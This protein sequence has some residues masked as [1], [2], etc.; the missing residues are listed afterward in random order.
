[1]D[2]IISFWKLRI[3]EYK[4]FKVNSKGESELEI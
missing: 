1:M 3:Q 4:Y 2:W